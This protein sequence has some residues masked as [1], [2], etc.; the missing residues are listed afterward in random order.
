MGARV[1]RGNAR[2][3]AWHGFPNFIEPDEG[4]R[5][6]ASYGDEKYA[7]LVEVK[8]CWDPENLFR[9]NQNIVAPDA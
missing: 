8:R 7:R 1:R 6:R 9:L 4:N 2:I 5:L 3:W